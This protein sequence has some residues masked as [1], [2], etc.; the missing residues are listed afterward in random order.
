MVLKGEEG[1]IS[2]MCQC[3]WNDWHYY[4]E[5]FN[6]FPFS[7]EALSRVLGLGKREGNWV[8]QQDIKENGEITQK[9]APC[10]LQVK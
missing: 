3:G 2:N 7:K 6:I 5:N 4:R 8:D 1:D 9:R 10:P